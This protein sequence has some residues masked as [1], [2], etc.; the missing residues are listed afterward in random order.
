MASILMGVITA[1]FIILIC[2]AC[3]YVGYKV[4]YANSPK[5][6]QRE[7]ANSTLTEA[8]QKR[9][10]GFANILNQANRHKAGDKK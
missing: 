8:Q 4:G 6:E 7:K 10:E 1:I 5:E 3:F 9:A 2:G